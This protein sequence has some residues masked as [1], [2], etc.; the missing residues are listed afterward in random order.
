[1]SV[2]LQD[3]LVK[4]GDIFCA[5]GEH[6]FVMEVNRFDLHERGRCAC[7]T[8]SRSKLPEYR[9]CRTALRF[10]RVVPWKCRGLDQRENNAGRS[11]F[12]P[13]I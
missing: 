11:I 1:M 8:R 9:R 6:R 12:P 10:E 4:V 13:S 2:D 7:S 3:A 5:P